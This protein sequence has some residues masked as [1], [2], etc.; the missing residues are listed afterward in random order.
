MTANIRLAL[1]KRRIEQF[2]SSKIEPPNDVEFKWKIR[3][4]G[5]TTEIEFIVVI[6]GIEI[7]VVRGTA[8][9]RLF[10]AS[11]YYKTYK[12][13]ISND[14]LETWVNS[15]KKQ[16]EAREPMGIELMVE[17][18]TIFYHS[19]TDETSRYLKEIHDKY[20]EYSQYM[21][22][23]SKEFIE[24]EEIE[25]AAKHAPAPRKAKEETQIDRIHDIARQH[26]WGMYHVGDDE[27][28]DIS[29]DTAE[30]NPAGGVI[31]SIIFDREQWETGDAKSWLRKNGYI[32]KFM[33]ITKNY[34]RFRQAP[35]KTESRN[36]RL[37]KFGDK[38]GI[39]AV[40]MF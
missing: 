13:K 12:Q 9:L 36:Y 26:R 35:F 22:Q 24:A 3:D 37:I 28:E 5:K 34:I 33:D 4:V 19:L 1:L 17:L 18:V 32:N 7:K 16:I 40:Y 20:I 31:Q 27:G 2:I 15:A 6:N 10:L 25:F 21:G 23:H 8:F 39:K 30:E 11:E 38:T 29:I 14:T